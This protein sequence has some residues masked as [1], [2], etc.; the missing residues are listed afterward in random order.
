M[1]PDFLSVCLSVRAPVRRPKSSPAKEYLV[2]IFNEYKE[3]KISRIN[4]TGSS[5]HS[6]S[7]QHTHVSDSL[8]TD[9][10]VG[11]IRTLNAHT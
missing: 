4:V 6:C 3:G 9:H 11:A 7:K 1:E 8:D 10:S 5:R 2:K